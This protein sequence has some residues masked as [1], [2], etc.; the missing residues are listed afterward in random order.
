MLSHLNLFQIK[1]SV[2]LSLEDHQS[3]SLLYQPLIGTH[4]LG[5]YHILAT[6]KPN[7]FYQHQ[8]LFDLSAVSKND[9]LEAQEKLE[10][11]NLLQTF[12]NSETQERI[13]WLNLPCRSQEFF[14]DPLF[15]NF[16]LSEVG[17]ATFLSLQN[18]FSKEASTK[19]NN[20]DA[21][22]DISKKF[23]DLF[24]VQ[25]M[26]LPTDFTCPNNQ[27]NSSPRQ[28]LNNAFDYK[29]FLQ[30]LPQRFKKPSLTCNQ[31]S[32]FIQ[33]LSLVYNLDEATLSE[34]YQ[35]TFPKPSEIELSKLSLGV[36]RY[37]QMNT[38][39]QNL[40]F[41][42]KTQ[43]NE[44]DTIALLKRK[45]STQRII[46]NHCP[47]NMQATAAD[48]VFQFMERNNL[49]P[50]L[51]NVLLTY[52]L[53]RKGFVPSVVYLEKILKSWEQ[54]GI[55]DTETAYDFY[56]EQEKTQSQTKFRSNLKKPQISPK[57]LED[58]KKKKQS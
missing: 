5:I 28:F 31:T 25:K 54:K 33:K 41:A 15:S 52:I 46:I 48:T 58:F 1:N 47:K 26:D 22:Q 2:F 3:L 19:K 56:M 10:A 37:Y 51:V 23:D 49:E 45:D 43:Y 32:D 27:T 18:H 35:K 20:W 55:F 13:Y 34:I 39:N 40:V 36:K 16:L 8:F 11:L 29:L 24:Q 4:A 17:E 12:C 42:K 53:E 21:F 50:G 6:L 14:K 38:Q 30:K 9:F 44:Q 57:W 7:I